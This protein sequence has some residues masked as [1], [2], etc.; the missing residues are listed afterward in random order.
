VAAP[1]QYV[2][3]LRLQSRRLATFDA[4][5]RFAVD[6]PLAIAGLVVLGPVVLVLTALDQLRGG[7]AIIET[8][9]ILGERGRTVH[10]PLL[11][12][13]ISQ[14]MLLRGYPA[15]FSVLRGDLALVGPRPI[16]VEEAAAFAHWK[17]LLIS[18]KP[19]LTGP[20]RFVGSELPSD[21]RVF[22]DVWW[23]RNWT[24]WRHLFVLFKTASTLAL[25]IFSKV[26]LTRWQ[27]PS[28]E[29]P[30][31]EWAPRS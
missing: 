13:T 28:L 3:L 16:A 9:A 23:V 18:V 7:K 8:R 19:G 11:S 31:Q 24:V 12:P 5:L 6:Y 4:V 21:E 1:L 22:A 29:H 10:V 26:G 25:S 14:A 2:P 15:L 30:A 17:R 20:W 27:R